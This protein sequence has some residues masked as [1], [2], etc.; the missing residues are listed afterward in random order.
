MMETSRVKT[1]HSA[2]FSAT[3]VSLIQHS[4]M[5]EFDFILV[6]FSQIQCLII[7]SDQC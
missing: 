1:Y 2:G 4:E 3:T 5:K 7:Y 6:C